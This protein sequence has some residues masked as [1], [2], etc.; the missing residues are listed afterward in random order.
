MQN[1]ICLPNPGKNPFTRT[2]FKMIQPMLNHVLALKEIN[3]HY[4]QALS[5][6]F[7][8]L[9]AAR[10]LKSMNIAVDVCAE[11]LDSIP[12]NG[13]LLIVSNHPFG[14]L[15][16]LILPTVFETIRP[17]MKFV[18]NY[19]LSLIPEMANMFFSV[20]PFQGEKS[21]TQNFK[22]IRQ[23]M[24]WLNEGHAISVFPAGEVSHLHLKQMQIMDGPWHTFAARIIQAT[25][26]HTVP[27]FFY[28]L[29][30]R[31][32][33]AMGVIHPLLRTLML[34]REMLKKQNH[35]ISVRIGSA[36]PP[37][38]ISTYD[39][40]EK[41]TDYLRLRTYILQN[42]QAKRPRFTFPRLRKKQNAYVSF[43]AEPENPDILEQEI[44]ALPK[45]NCLIDK[46]P[47]LVYYFNPESCPH[48]LLE[49]GRLREITFRNVG[50]GTGKIRDID[51]YDSYYTH[52]IVWDSTNRQLVGA[53]RAG[54]T[55]K[56]LESKGKKGL[57]TS[58]LFNYK[59]NLLEQI[60]PALELGRSF[61][62]PQYQKQFSSL[63]LLWKGIGQFVVNNP[64]YRYLFGPVSISRDYSDLAR[65]F[66]KLFLQQNYNFPELAK[67]VKPLNP[68]KLKGIKT[69]SQSASSLVAKDMD[70]VDELI[71]EMETHLEGIPIL[72]RQYLKL[73]AKL[74][75]FNIDPDFGHVLDA[76]LLVDLGHVDTKILYKY[77]GREGAETFLAHHSAAAQ[78]R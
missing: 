6:S 12:R 19:L 69:W 13:P 66:L 55:D 15:E 74:L 77:M 14:G 67:K 25:Q 22:G 35:T 49:I 11:E 5:S 70:E 54:K 60:S 40:P 4:Q 64:Q 21:T 34:P 18:A 62:Q 27:V 63:M 44:N 8:E 2:G 1:M 71:R 43:V 51:D 58:T 76:L 52:I 29:N 20:N 32:F 37:E 78:I 56:I 65:W 26:C 57:Y 42:R 17:D 7:P 10:V 24:E 72:L 61:I 30:S 48:L 47:M 38:K 46:P 39:T 68:L 50:E 28:G 41:L 45:K 33:Q 36:I 75:G 53:Y 3:Y 59:S 23:A 73:D 9:L 31:L 16:G